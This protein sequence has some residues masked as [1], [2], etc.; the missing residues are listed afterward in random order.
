MQVSPDNKKRKT[1]NLK[2]TKNKK[3]DIQ[4]SRQKLLDIENNKPKDIQDIRE[5]KPGIYKISGT[6][7]TK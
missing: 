3:S 1:Y 2:L 5:N 4:N 6:T 7:N